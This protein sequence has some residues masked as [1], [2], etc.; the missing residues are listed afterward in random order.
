MTLEELI[1]KHSKV[2][3]YFKLIS[4]RKRK[5]SLTV[6]FDYC[7]EGIWGK[8]ASYRFTRLSK[9]L[10]KEFLKWIKDTERT[11]CF[12]EN[13]KY[14]KKLIDDK[15][16]ELAKKLKKELRAFKILIQKEDGSEYIIF[17]NK[18]IKIRNKKI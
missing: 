1:A 6:M 17:E 13:N 18:I 7:S 3:N 8:G 2:I 11:Y 15:G 5:N 14:K 12:Y 16:L 10:Q 4:N 9:P